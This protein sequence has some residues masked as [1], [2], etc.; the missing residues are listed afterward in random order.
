MN[1]RFSLL[2][3]AALVLAIGCGA[4]NNPTSTDAA[5]GCGGASASILAGSCTY[6]AFGLTTCAE[7]YYT[8]ALSSSEIDVQRQACSGNGFTYST[9]DLCPTTSVACKCVDTT[10]SFK[11]IKYG[12]GTYTDACGTCTGQC[13]SK[14]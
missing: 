11:R 5:V 2:C 6:T 4:N 14:Q 1:L 10:G 8:H 12:Y 7:D 3:T 9:T 13:Y